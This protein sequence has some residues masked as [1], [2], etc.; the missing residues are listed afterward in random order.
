MT[1]VTMIKPGWEL[2][3][4][5]GRPI[6][7]AFAAEW[8][9]GRV[10]GDWLQNK[11]LGLGARIDHHQRIT[12][13]HLF[14]PDV[15]KGTNAFTGPLPGELTWATSRVAVNALFE[16][17]TASGEPQ[18]E[19]TSI[20]YSPYSWD[21]WDVAGKGGI[22][23]EYREDA[24]SIRMIT[25]SEPPLP[26]A[27]SVELR[28]YADYYQFYVADA[29][30]T[31][32]TGVIWDDPETTKR[33]IAQGDG[34]IAIGTK[35]YG[36]VPV[37]VE[38]YPIEPK[39]DPRGIDRINECSLTITTKLGIGNYISSSELT[40]IDIAPGTYG[41]RALY[42]HQDQVENDE[43][44]NDQYVLQFWPVTEPLKLRYIKP[45]A[46]KSV[47]KKPAASKKSGVKS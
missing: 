14:G 2:L 42:I 19:P 8:F 4:V 40:P 34:L 36:A 43:K 35:R 1:D 30:S 18:G 29:A 16:A 17:P 15:E 38:I 25:L 9:G 27:T 32:D 39:L 20:F 5:C 21:R 13:L 7:E 11:A 26:E 10:K 33:Q 23:V 24:K 41:V 12:S 3:A 47:A 28:V 31:C 6:T 45:A 22:H 44:G 46:K 37:R